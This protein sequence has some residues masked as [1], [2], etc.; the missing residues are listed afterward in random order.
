MIE[1]LKR[2]DITELEVQ[3]IWQQRR[4]RM[5]LRRQYFEP[6][7]RNG[8][9]QFFEGIISK[10]TNNTKPLYNTLYEQYDFTLFS[11][12]GLRFSQVK[13]PLIHAVAMRAMANEIKNK[14]RPNFVAVGSNDPSK[15]KAF[16]HLF[17][18]VL[19]E[20]DADQEDFETFLD[21]R[22]FGSSVSMVL[23]ES[24]EI[25]VEDP[26]YNKKTGEYTYEKKKKKIYQCLYKKLDLRHVFFDEHCTKT[27]LTDCNYAQ[28]DEY[29]SKD[30]A[31][32][33]LKKYPA[34]KVKQALSTEM[35]KEDQAVYFNLYDTQNVE[36]VRFT[37]CFDKIYDRYHLLVNGKL[38]NEIKSP[39]PRIAGRRGK[40]IPLALSVMYKIPG[41]PYGYGDSH[42][43]TNFNYIKNLVRLMILEITQKM[44]KPTIAVDPMSNFDEQGFEWGQDFI[45]VSPNDLREIQANP[46]LKILYDLDSL[47]DNDII[48]VTG[49]NFNDT[50]NVDVS[51]T[52]RKTIIRRESQNAIIELT[53]D[54]MSNSYFKRLYTLLKDDVRLHY[55]AMMKSGEAIK[56]RTDG[57][58]LSRKNGGYD[59]EKV[60]G[61]RYF[62]LKPEDIDFDMDL[63]LELGNIAS[64]RELDKAI[65]G[66]GIDAALK[67]PEGFDQ[68]GLAKWTQETYKM[69]ESVLAT[70]GK[71]ISDMD[72]EELAKQN[73][74][75]EMIPDQQQ[76]QEQVNNPPQDVPQEVP[77][78]QE[79]APALP[80]LG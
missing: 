11:K 2:G 73:I 24:Y 13:Y 37:H 51:E 25:E 55:G 15:P 34:D 42:I 58:Y 48:R 65:A 32:Q 75:P 62:D 41:A 52:A 50:T 31:E 33:R 5:S 53:M 28:V 45:R 6:L 39:I 21:R 10:N 80:Q 30:E 29:F 16:R 63:D 57:T 69:P 19:Y 7:W 79:A 67:I 14:P 20:M 47:T 70:Q 54:Y 44:A 74:P 8:I 72:P 36:H 27:T 3:S 76:A 17:D 1:D 71:G 77:P 9:G 18:Q 35:D 59:E 23:A 4:S 12:D 60:V 64:S 26:T 22:I 56:I 68:A 49:I 40:D 46:N 38:V 66:E 78:G 43:T 61:F